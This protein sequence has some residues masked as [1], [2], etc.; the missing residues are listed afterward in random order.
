MSCVRR[1]SLCFR[2]MWLEDRWL[3]HVLRTNV[4]VRISICRL[5]F[6]SLTQPKICIEN[7]YQTWTWTP[8]LTASV[9]LSK[10]LLCVLV[11]SGKETDLTDA[12]PG[13]IRM[14]GWGLLSACRQK[15]VP[16]CSWGCS[17]DQPPG[18]AAN[19]WKAEPQN[20][21]RSCEASLSVWE[22]EV[23]DLRMDVCNQ[24][25]KSTVLLISVL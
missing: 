7:T 9:V 16:S 22:A 2:N 6:C 21:G 10:E 17:G 14:N 19:K 15:V 5:C 13:I 3:K 18:P 11:S 24:V 12:T 8:P 1:L 20:L 4:F 25:C 23:N